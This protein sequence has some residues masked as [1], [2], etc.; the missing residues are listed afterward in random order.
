[1]PAAAWGPATN[2]TTASSAWKGGDSG[3]AGDWA[4]RQGPGYSWNAG[5]DNGH[6]VA[7]VSKHEDGVFDGDKGDACRKYAPL[8]LLRMLPLLT[9]ELIAAV[10]PAISLASVQNRERRAETAS[11]AASQGS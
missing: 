4:S 8:T 6:G 7:N 2:E 11:I 10:S 9:E 1:M 3:A 5:G